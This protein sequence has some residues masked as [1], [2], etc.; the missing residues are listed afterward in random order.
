[1]FGMLGRRLYL[2]LGQEQEAERKVLAI[3]DEKDRIMQEMHSLRD[4]LDQKEEEILRMEQNQS[5]TKNARIVE[6]QSR[7]QTVQHECSAKD[8]R[9]EELVS[10]HNDTQEQYESSSLEVLLLVLH[11]FEARQA[12]RLRNQLKDTNIELNSQI[13]GLEKQLNGKEAI[14]CGLELRTSAEHKERDAIIKTAQATNE[15]LKVV[16][17]DCAD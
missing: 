9:I 2:S 14:I 16:G 7:L 6:L 3:Q 10:R 13:S 8:E 5:A 11:L 12:E 17:C 15:T 4:R 1:M